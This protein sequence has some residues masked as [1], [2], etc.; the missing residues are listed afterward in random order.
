[1][2]SVVVAVMTMM[3]VVVMWPVIKEE[4]EV[5]MNRC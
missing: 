3:A 5:V 4:A 2:V 1:M